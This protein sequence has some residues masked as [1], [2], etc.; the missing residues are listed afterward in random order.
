[1]LMQANFR[2][3]IDDSGECI[4]RGCFRTSIRSLAARWGW[5]RSRVE[6]FLERLASKPET[7][8]ETVGLKNETLIRVLKYESYQAHTMGAETL[9]ET[10]PPE[11]RDTNRDSALVSLRARDKQIKTT[12]KPALPI[13]PSE[14]ENLKSEF[15]ATCLKYYLRKFSKK[16]SGIRNP[17]SYLRKAIREDRK[18]GKNF[19]AAQESGSNRLER[20][21]LKDVLKAQGV[22]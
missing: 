4:R 22:E 9:G 16:F 14:I 12:N 20:K 8:I 11:N 19:F 15:G 3:Q 21:L 17:E 2:D 10:P 18:L 13:G 6:R 5:H 1:M 7:Q